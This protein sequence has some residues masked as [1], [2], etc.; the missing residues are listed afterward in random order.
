M[1][2]TPKKKRLLPKNIA[3]QSDAVVAEKLFGKRAKREL[4]RLTGAAPKSH[5][6]SLAGI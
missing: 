2:Q 6:G 4:D 3:Q 5:E 1:A